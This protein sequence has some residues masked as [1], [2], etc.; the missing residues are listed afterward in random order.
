MPAPVAQQLPGD[1]RALDLVGAFVDLGDLG[2]PVEPLDLEALDVA[3]AAEDLDRVGGARH[4]HV[5]GE[6]LGHRAGRVAG[7]PASSMHRGRL[8]SSPAASMSLAMS[9]SS[10]CTPWNSAIGLAELAALPG[11]I[12]RGLQPRLGDADGQRRDADPA[13]VEHAHH[14]VK[15][16]PLLTQ[17]RIG[18]QPHVV[19]GRARRPGD[20]RWPILCSLGPR[21]ALAPQVDD[22]DRHA[23]IAGRRV[24]AGEHEAE[25]RHGRVV[26]PELDPSSRQPSPRRAPPSSDARDVAAGLGLGDAV[27][28]LAS[29]RACPQMV[30]AF[31]APRCRARQQRADQLDQ[32]ALV[33]HRGVAAGRA[34]PSPGIGQRVETGAAQR[35]GHGDAEQAER[36][37]SLVELGRKRLVPIQRLGDRAGSRLRRGRRI[38]SDGR[39]PCPSAA[40]VKQQPVGGLRLYFRCRR[41]DKGPRSDATKREGGTTMATIT[42]T[43]AWLVDLQ[44]KVKRTDA[45]QS[46]VSQETPIVRII[47]AD[48]GIGTGYTYTIGTGGPRS[49]N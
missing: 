4:R 27:G 6:A 16:A 25:I 5:A 18:R 17:Q 14:H 43:E 19:E 46:F 13:L 31:A 22:E 35:L 11:I 26:D 33:G 1:D 29:R 8:D 7:C 23:A 39:A 3:G 21:D 36:P 45:I 42:R 47:D 24:R 9:A 10:H 34:P 30:P 15:A 2:V 28:D 40:G 12:Q 20:A 41:I 44:P 37:I 38:V 49:W 48:G 32:P